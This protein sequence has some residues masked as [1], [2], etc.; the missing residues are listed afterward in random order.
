[1]MG[2]KIATLID[3]V[4][5]AGEHR[6]TWNAQDGRYTNLAS[7]LYFCKLKAQSKE[8]DDRFEMVQKVM[9]LK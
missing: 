4:E 9:L 3:G 8:S 5:E 2:Q 7:G 1:L 6:Y